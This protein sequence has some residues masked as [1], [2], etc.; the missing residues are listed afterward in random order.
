MYGA[1]ILFA[2]LGF[3]EARRFGRQYGRTPW[4]WSPWTWGVICGL[5]LL[6][7]AILLA[8]ARHQ[9]ISASRTSS[10]DESATLPGR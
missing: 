10:P 2:I 5:S 7:G 9:G 3:L 8:V 6:V 4:G 1:F